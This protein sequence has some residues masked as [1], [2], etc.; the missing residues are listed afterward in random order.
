MLTVATSASVLF[1]SYSGSKASTT[2]VNVAPGVDYF[3]VNNVSI[4]LDVF[5]THQEGT[6]F[7]STGA[8]TNSDSTSVGFAP[9]L[10]FNAP[11]TAFLSFWPQVEIGYGIEATNE[12]SGLG[13]NQHSRKRSWVQISAP[14]LIHPTSHFF[15]G[16]G[17]Y[18]FH[19]L[20]DADQ[21]DY[22]NDVTTLGSSLVLGGWL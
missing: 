13:T 16:G 19:E 18:L 11:L 20:T 7:D 8:Q 22:E 10:G 17:P 12:V 2:S 4:G 14:L 1:R 15:V 5:V 9:R 6:S 21:Y 3:V